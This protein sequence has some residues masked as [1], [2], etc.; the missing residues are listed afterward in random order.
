MIHCEIPLLYCD[1]LSVF[2]LLCHTELR[3]IHYFIEQSMG[4]CYVLDTAKYWG[5]MDEH[6]P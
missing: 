2:S 5:Y 4:T 6:S 1:V 3:M